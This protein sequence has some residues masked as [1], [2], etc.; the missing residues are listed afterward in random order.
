MFG[1]SRTSYALLQDFLAAVFEGKPGPTKLAE[2]GRDLFQVVAVLADERVLRTTLADPAGSKEGKSQLVTSLFGGKISD[3]ALSHL[4]EIVG[5][6]WSNDADM[7]DAVEESGASM[8]LMAAEDLN[9][10]DQVEEELF[11]F[12]RAIDANADLQMALTDP[13]ASPEAK[14]KIV[15]TLLEGKANQTTIELVS[16]VAGSL[17][18]RRIQAAIAHLSTLAAARRGQILAEVTSAVALTDE[19]KDR[20]ARALTKLHGRPVELNVEV[21]PSVLG[22]IEVR[23]GDEVIDGTAATKLEQARRRLAG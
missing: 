8:L 12:G 13:A 16:E 1:S 4:I 18:G 21:D 3:V 10:I 14:A 5:A 22:G 9:Q 6:R 20:L 17:R 2:A 11:R 23:V 19:Q 7:V 15:S